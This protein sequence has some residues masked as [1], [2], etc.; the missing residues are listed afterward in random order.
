M[1]TMI[2]LHTMRGLTDADIGCFFDFTGRQEC[3]EPRRPGSF[4][5]SE[6]MNRIIAAS[7]HKV[8]PRPCG[9]WAAVEEGDHVTVGEDTWH[10][11]QAVS[12]LFGWR[13][14][15]RTLT[16]ELRREILELI[17]ARFKYDKD[18]IDWLEA[19]LGDEIFC[20]QW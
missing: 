12:D 10:G 19:H 6:P 1:S 9:H 15:M 14:G 8:D 5:D 11:H 17:G 7:D 3:T 16:P 4:Y 13:A 20:I 18:I 2:K